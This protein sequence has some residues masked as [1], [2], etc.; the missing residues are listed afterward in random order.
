M[1]PFLVLVLSMVIFGATAQSNAKKTIP[2]GGKETEHKVV[3]KENWYSVGR[4]YGMSPKDIAAYNGLGLE[5]GLKIGQ[6]IKIPNVAKPQPEK[7][8]SE[9]PAL[10]QKPEVTTA[11]APVLKK[12]QGGGFFA[13]AYEQQS[14]EG[15]KQQLDNPLFGIFKSTSGW[16][17]GKYYLLLNG[18]VPGTVVKIKSSSTGNVVYAKVLGSVPLGKENQGLDMRMS[19]ATAAAL[20]LG[21]QQSGGV[22]LV[23]FN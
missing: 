11:P 7:I 21:E 14:R 5:N 16:Q 6:V 1:K 9:L 12:Q 18:A 23:W 13:N 10:P 19:N 2:G 3:A 15:K 8:H 4:L 20:G 17:D 22:E